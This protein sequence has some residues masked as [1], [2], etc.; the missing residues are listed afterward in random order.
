MGGYKPEDD[1]EY[2]AGKAE[3]QQHVQSGNP[4]WDE[5]S[6]GGSGGKGCSIIAAALITGSGIVAAYIGHKYGAAT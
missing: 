6:E 1:P 2:R 3:L 4:E 5:Y